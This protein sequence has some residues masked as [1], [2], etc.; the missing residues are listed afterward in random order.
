MSFRDILFGDGGVSVRDG[1]SEMAVARRVQNRWRR[2][3]S[4]D[5]EREAGVA[6]RRPAAVPSAMAA[7]AAGSS[8]TNTTNANTTQRYTLLLLLAL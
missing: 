5:G 1:V 8:A 6:M 3:V 4:N 7:I 2:R